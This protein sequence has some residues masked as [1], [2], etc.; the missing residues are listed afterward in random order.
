MTGTVEH[1]DVALLVLLCTLADAAEGLDVVVRESKFITLDVHVGL[2]QNNAQL[3]LNTVGIRVVLCVLQQ[4]ENEVGGA[5]I[6][7]V[8]QPEGAI[9]RLNEGD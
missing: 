2:A 6:Q 4:F 7:L 5:G 3:W 8:A 1:T 9:S